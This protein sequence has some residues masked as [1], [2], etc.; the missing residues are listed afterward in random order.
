MWGAYLDDMSDEF[1]TKDWLNKVECIGNKSMRTAQGY[2]R[3]MIQAKMVPAM[4]MVQL[5]E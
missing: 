4:A 1:T 5:R 2:L 3:S